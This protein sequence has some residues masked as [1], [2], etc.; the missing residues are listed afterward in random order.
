MNG[1]EA[2]AYAKLYIDM[3]PLIFGPAPYI[4]NIHFDLYKSLKP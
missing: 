1:Y 2:L 3:L 4:K